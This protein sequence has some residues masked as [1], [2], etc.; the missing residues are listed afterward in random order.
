MDAPGHRAPVLAYVYLTVRTG[1]RV[2]LPE[3]HVRDILL[4]DG[5]TRPNDGGKYR[6]IVIRDRE[7]I[8]KA[9]PLLQAACDSLSRSASY[10]ES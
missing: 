2:L 5:F 10:I 1:L 8:R 3:K 7:Q 4:E 9:E 6:Q